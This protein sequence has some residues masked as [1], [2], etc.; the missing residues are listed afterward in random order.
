[1]WRVFPVVWE[2]DALDL[3]FARTQSASLRRWIR[4]CGSI[5]LFAVTAGVEM[6]RLIRRAQ[7]VSPLHGML[8][9]AIGA[10]RVEAGCDRLCETLA[11]EM[12]DR[13]FV[14]RFS[15]GYGDLPM[16]MQRDVFLALDCQRLLGLT[17]TEEM[18]MVPGKSVTAIVGMKGSERP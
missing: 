5:V 8:M 17:L 2:K 7:A 16:D 12:P 11:G 14:P 6:D 18:L 10:E 4:G 1:M 13:V 9:H 15:P 3:T